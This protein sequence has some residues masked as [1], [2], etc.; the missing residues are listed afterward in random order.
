MRVGSPFCESLTS[1]FLRLSEAHCVTP[2]RLFD[3]GLNLALG[4]NDQNSRGLVGPSDTFGTWQINGNGLVAEKWVKALKTITLREDLSA[5]TLLPFHEAF[6]KRDACRRERAWCPLC[7]DDLDQSDG[8]VYEQLL[9]TH[10][11]VN[12]CAVHDVALQTCCPHCGR[13]SHAL[14]GSMRVGRCAGCDGWLGALF[15]RA[16]NESKRTKDKSDEYQIFVTN[17]I[18]S[19]IAVSRD[20][21]YLFNKNNPKRAI[22]ELLARCFNGNIRAFTRYLGLNRTADSSLTNQGTRFVVLSLLLKLAFISQTP[23]LDLLTN[24]CALA[25]FSPIITRTSRQPSPLLIAK[26]ESV[27]STLAAAAHET[28]PPSLD[29]V[30]LRLACTTSRLRQHSAETCKLITKNYRMSE[31]GRQ[32]LAARLR[33]WRSSAADIEAAFKT[34]LKKERPPT[35]DQLAQSLG[36]RNRFGLKHRVPDL[37]RALLQKHPKRHEA[38]RQFVESE[39]RKSLQTDPPEDLLTAAQRL[40]YVSTH[41]LGLR[42]KELSRKIRARYEAHQKVQSLSKMRAQLNAVLSETP[43][44]TLKDSMRKLSVSDKWLREYLPDERR[45]IAARYLIY[46]REQSIANKTRDRERIR[47]IVRDFHNTGT[48]P[49]MNAV[50]DVFS[51]SALK[52]TDVW[53]TIKQAREELLAT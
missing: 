17:E 48:F 28:P 25:S 44:P 51:A 13:I 40:G 29:E 38:R 41:E 16:H 53:A 10:K 21:E 43:P 5:L 23:L 20:T 1:Y 19:L 47:A 8:I 7:L 12:A 9:W 42:Y 11:F 52:R 31:R 36:Y 15:R 6:P 4:K 39:L 22:G 3:N 30:A 14:S 32:T 2:R 46:R 50:L 49:S 26:K 33:G 35:L 34:A 27:L 37:C 18:G 45:S 24:E